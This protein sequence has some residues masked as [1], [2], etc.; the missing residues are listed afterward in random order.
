MARTHGKNVDFSFNAVTID[1]E[2]SK[3]EISFDVAEADITSFNDAWQNFLAGKKDTKTEIEGSY[4]PLAGTGIATIFAVLGGG[5]V[6]TLFDVTGSGPAAGNPE[7]Q[8][9]ASGLTGVLVQS[10]RM[11][12]PVNEKASY[13]ATLQHSG[14][15]TRAVV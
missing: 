12:F 4:D 5:P 9:T 3:V 11:S 10:L 15:T 13:R 6:T 14:S 2:L 7:Y 8:C 1:D